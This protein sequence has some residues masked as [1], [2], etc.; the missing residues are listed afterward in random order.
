M[1]ETH[2]FTYPD[3]V[4]VFT[5]E[6]TETASRLHSHGVSVSY[7]Q[8]TSAQCR[9]LH[10]REYLIVSTLCDEQDSSS[11]KRTYHDKKDVAWYIDLMCMTLVKDGWIPAP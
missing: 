9:C 3:S 6:V 5:I 2:T 1:N 4:K 8:F 7:T 10:R 11:V